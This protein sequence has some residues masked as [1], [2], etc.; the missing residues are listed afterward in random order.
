MR[1]RPD[2]GAY[3]R[4]N[5]S[6]G[7]S[8]YP[9]KDGCRRCSFSAFVPW[10]CLIEFRASGIPITGEF[11]FQLDDVKVPLGRST[12]DAAVAMTRAGAGHHY[13]AVV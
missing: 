6:N 8:C 11:E 2:R 5:V 1:W 4:L 9:W 7:I 10:D 12:G 13:P 3:A